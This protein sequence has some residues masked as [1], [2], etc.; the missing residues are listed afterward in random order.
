MLKYHLAILQRVLMHTCIQE[1]INPTDSNHSIENQY[2]TIRYKYLPGNNFSNHGK[3]FPD[4]Y[5]NITVSCSQSC[6]L[7]LGKQ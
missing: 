7:S 6:L 2:A 1:T 5:R 4:R 3:L